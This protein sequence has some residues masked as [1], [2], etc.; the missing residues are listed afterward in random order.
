M[1]IDP[2]RLLLL[3]AI[4]DH[5][6]VTRAAEHTGRTPP[7]V[8]QQLAR[9]EDE[10]GALLVERHPHGARLTPLGEQMALRADEIADSLRRAEDTAADYLD[11]HRNRLRLGA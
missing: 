8:S 6:G 1:A 11:E 9:L 2:A 5:G 3:A 7:A 4:R 10:A